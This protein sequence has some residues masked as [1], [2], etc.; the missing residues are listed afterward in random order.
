MI[1]SKRH[2]TSSILELPSFK[3]TNFALTDFWFFGLQL[4]TDKTRRVILITILIRLR[5]LECVHAKLDFYPK[6]ERKCVTHW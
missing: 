6:N 3:L 1:I 5:Q 4:A 2:L